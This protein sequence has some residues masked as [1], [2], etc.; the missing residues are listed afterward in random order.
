MNAVQNLI[1]LFICFL[2]ERPFTIRVSYSKLSRKSTRQLFGWFLLFCVLFSNV[3]IRCTSVSNFIFWYAY[4]CVFLISIHTFSNANLL[5]NLQH[6]QHCS[7]DIE[8]KL[9][10]SKLYYL[11]HGFN[12]NFQI[13]LE[14]LFY[15]S[16]H[17]NSNEPV[18]LLLKYVHFVLHFNQ[19]K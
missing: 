3:Y 2:I 19:W 5:H 12:I 10:Y 13:S 6:L 15:L 17:A 9:P 4:H 1:H 7:I 14:M 18:Y 11:S 16:A 8:V